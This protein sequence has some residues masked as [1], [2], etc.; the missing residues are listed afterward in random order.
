MPTLAE[1]D[2]ACAATETLEQAAQLLGISL[3]A[4]KGRRK[5]AFAADQIGRA[6]V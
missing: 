1:I 3:C 2:A 5:R 6:H 4:L